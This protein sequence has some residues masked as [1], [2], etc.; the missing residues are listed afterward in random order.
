M[1]F[2][3]TS[4]CRYPDVVI[5]DELK[6]STTTVK[7]K[8]A[9]KLETTVKPQGIKLKESNATQAVKKHENNE[10]PQKVVNA[11]TLKVDKS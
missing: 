11:T 8:I 1:A 4:D 6:D 7:P 2:A 9:V 3:K 5:P 10:K